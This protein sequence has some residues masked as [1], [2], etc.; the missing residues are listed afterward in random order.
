MAFFRKDVFLINYWGDQALAGAQVY[1]CNQ[2]ADASSIPPVPLATIYADS[3]GTA[4]P[5]PVLLD[6]QGNGFYYAAEGLYTEVYVFQGR[7]VRVLPDQNIAIGGSGLVSSVFSRTGD[8][9][10]ANGDYNFTQIAGIADPTQ[11]PTPTSTT[12]GGVRS[13]APVAHEWIDSIS[14]SGVPHLSQ[15]AYSDLTGAPPAP[16]T[17]APVAHEF[18]KGYTS[19]TGL[20]TSAPPDWTDLTNIPVAI[21]G[22]ATPQPQ[23]TFFSGPVSGAAAAPTFR[24]IT[25][26]DLPTL[27][28]L[29]QQMV[30]TLSTADLFAIDTS[31]VNITPTP[32]AGFMVFPTLVLLEYIAGTRPFGIIGNDTVFEQR[33]NGLDAAVGKDGGFA[34]AQIVTSPISQIGTMGA[35]MVY[36]DTAP[37][38]GVQPIGSYG[39][40]ETV[41][42]T[43]TQAIAN[44]ATTIYKGTITN[45]NTSEGMYNGYTFTVT[46]FA[47]AANNGT[48]I[49]T[50]ATNSTSTELY[51]VNASGV[52]ETH[53]A[54][55]TSVN[56]VDGRALQLGSRC[57]LNGGG[58]TAATVTGGHAGAGYAVNNTGTIDGVLGG[59]YRVASV[60]G[61][62]VTSVTIDV[63]GNN[64]EAGATGVP[65][66]PITGGGDG[67]LQLDIT[68]VQKGN[69]SLKVTAYYYVVPLP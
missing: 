34:A 69:G 2:P 39:P 55:A 64:Y 36:G 57:S 18:L 44:G 4:L 63:P 58:V 65:T 15:P 11:L 49:H 37:G 54:T 14:T 1:V 53:A 51:L 9:V 20:F 27:P 29:P 16:L 22:I 28:G 31:P 25:T 13:I 38:G 67:D 48:F 32:S 66:Q 26:N 8:V 60:A 10:A 41:V 19:G 43:L 68:T 35:A 21:S 42:L 46:G 5:Q 40:T 3:I 59:I 50:S 47:N 24:A 33:Y 30:T 23:N 7:V 12:I 61:G 56:K 62:A 45:G 17:F 52:N 6:G